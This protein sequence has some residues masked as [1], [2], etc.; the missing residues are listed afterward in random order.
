MKR[1]RFIQSAATAS[2]ASLAVPTLT[3]AHTV[4]SSEQPYPNHVL[5]IKRYLKEP[6]IIKSIDIVKTQGERFVVVTSTEGIKGITLLNFRMEFF[7]PVLK[8]MLTPFFI[9]KDARDIEQIIHHIL[10]SRSIYKY[11]GIP[12]FNSL[13][14]IEISIMDLLGKAANMPS[15]MF[16][17]KRIRNELPMYVSSLTR[18]TS[19]E[20]EVDILK[21]Q[22]A[23]T[24][25][26]AV[27]IKIGGRMSRNQD[28]SAGRT[29]KLVPLTRKVLGDQITIYADANSSYDANQGIKVAKMLEEYGVAIFEEPC[30]WEDYES[31]R[32]VAA[33]LKKMKLAGGEQDTS[34]L[35]F[36]DIVK[37][38]VYHILQPDL[39]Y[40]GGILRTF[41]VAQLAATNKLTVAPH[42]PKADP[43]AAPF[44]QFA[45]VA[46]NLE[47]FQ[48]Y[49]G[50]KKQF[51]N[52]YFPHFDINDGKVKIPDGP[53][54]G[55]SYDEAI[56]K[57]AE[58]I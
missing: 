28:A 21:R 37:N 45:S 14:H 32:K 2:L 13:G 56:W 25:A 57:N 48:E 35:R 58:T 34:Y 27:K 23:E 33:S 8:G 52:W 7:I 24:G 55:L 42:S 18:D 26:K 53:G 49:P 6:V 16:F 20:E 31:N 39:Y 4:I 19:P 10:H 40:N 30:Y 46:T 54:L 38:K 11:S 1:R 15:G 12:L 3:S 50:G 5:D 29:E 36:K 43:L 9:G 44:F 41:Y 51:P 17:G 47:G 22:L